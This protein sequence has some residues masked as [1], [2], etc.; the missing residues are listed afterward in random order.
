M[1]NSSGLH[2]LLI[3]L[4]F[5]CLLCPKDVVLPNL[6]RLSPTCFCFFPLNK[7]Y[8]EKHPLNPEDAHLTELVAQPLPSGS[9]VSG[10][11]PSW[12]HHQ[13]HP[14]LSLA[15]DRANEVASPHANFVVNSFRDR[16]HCFRFLGC[17]RDGHLVS[18]Y[19]RVTRSP[20]SSSSVC[21]TIFTV[22]QLLARLCSRFCEF[23]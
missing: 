12:H 2:S 7:V 15:G 21:F 22:H 4:P 9:G 5:Q 17:S 10:A 13:P 14:S 11:C 1:R 6:E 8:G 20:L 3:N 16:D 23:K 19:G 18:E